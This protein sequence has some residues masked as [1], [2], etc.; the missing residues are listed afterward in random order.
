MAYASRKGRAL[1]TEP[2]PATVVKECAK[3]ENK[4]NLP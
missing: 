1:P 2:I 3:L 4:G